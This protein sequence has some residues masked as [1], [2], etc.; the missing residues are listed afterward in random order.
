MAPISTSPF[1]YRLATLIFRFDLYNTYFACFS[2]RTEQGKQY[3]I[4]CRK[5]ADSA[6]ASEQVIL[7][8]NELAV[9]KAF[10]TL[11]AKAI[12]PNHRFLA[13]STDEKGD[14]RHTLVIKDLET[15]QLLSD[16]IENTEY[17]IAWGNDNKTLYYITEDETNRPYRVYRHIVGTPVDS[18]ELLLEE[19]DMKYYLSVSR[20]RDGKYVVVDGQSKLTHECSFL[21]ADDSKSKLTVFAPRVQGIEYSIDHQHGHWLITTNQDSATN[22]KLLAVADSAFAD[23]SKW[24]ELIPHRPDV[25]LDGVDCFADYLVCWERKGGMKTL[26]VQRGIKSQTPD[27]YGTAAF[28][29]IAFPEASWALFGSQNM[30]YDTNLFRFVY[31]SLTTPRSVFDYNLADQ[32][33]T[34]VK[35]DEVLGGYDAS[36]YAT[37]REFAVSHDGTKVPVSIVYKK[38]MFK[39]DGSNPCLLYGYG[40]YGY[41]IDPFFSSNR[42][43]LLNRGFV[44]AIAHIRGGGEN[45]RLWYEHGKL[46]NKKNTFHDFIA[47]AKHLVEANFATSSRLAIQGGSA[48]GLL[49]GAVANMAPEGLIQAVVAEVP[50]VD[51][52]STMLD[53]TL[54]L[55]VTE[56]EEWGNPNE[57][58]YFDYM[59]SYAPYDNVV[60]KKYPHVL[61]TAGLNDPRVSYWEPAKWISRLRQQPNSADSWFLMKTKMESGHAGASGRY[62][63]LRDV[64]FVYSFVMDRLGVKLE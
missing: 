19:P 14:E 44:F 51:S 63:Y 38:S 9:G 62:D 53:P 36:E 8:Q 54:P 6:D 48:G 20:S 55:T 1:L 12:S 32:T 34:L 33:R 59:R 16:K 18:D 23:K 7:D 49:V 50:F 31:S 30:E 3:P 57:R 56:Y 45:G 42:L 61:A 46:M 58:E 22:F 43:A 15:G 10:C 11:G 13:Y 4:Y 26:R 21:D 64:A 28:E 47:A 27:N 35:Q 29:E 41:S 25:K 5:K 39:R 60:N 40:S 37:E 2:S 24:R 17:S 52:L